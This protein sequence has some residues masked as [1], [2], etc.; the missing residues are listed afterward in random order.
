M[1]VTLPKT[2]NHYGSILFNISK[3]QDFQSDLVAVFFKCTKQQLS[4]YRLTPY[5]WESPHPCSDESDE[6][7]TTLNMVNCLWHNCGSLLQQGSDIAPRQKHSLRVYILC[8]VSLSRTSSILSTQLACLQ[9][10]KYFT[11]ERKK[12]RCNTLNYDTIF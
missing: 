5:E 11:S 7:E 4:F 10:Q 6:L 2:R 1:W 9:S 12:A 8:A 3:H